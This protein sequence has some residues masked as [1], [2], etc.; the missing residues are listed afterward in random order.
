MQHKRTLSKAL[1]FFEKPFSVFIVVCVLSFAPARPASSQASTAHGA[2]VSVESELTR[3]VNPFVGTD[4][5]GNTFPGATVP[6]GMVQLSPDTTATGWYKYQDSKIRG[7]SL[8]HFSGA[9]CAAYA[10]VPFMPAIGPLK[11]PPGPNGPEYAAPFSHRKE[12]AGPG[13]SAVE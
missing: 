11:S 12:Q 5:D 6:F 10:D 13:N 7:F 9:G 2:T 3:L 4:N 8:T 1:N